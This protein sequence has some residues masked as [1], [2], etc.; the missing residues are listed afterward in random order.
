[1]A[2]NP[3]EFLS[4][5]LGPFGPQALYLVVSDHPE[6]NQVVHGVVVIYGVNVFYSGNESCVFFCNLFLIVLYMYFICFLLSD[7]R[8]FIPIHVLLV[9]L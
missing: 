3:S 1:M 4:T 7:F 2:Q 5:G 6:K 8:D 9:S